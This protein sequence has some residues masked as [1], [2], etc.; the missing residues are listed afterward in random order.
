MPWRGAVEWQRRF[1]PGGSVSLNIGAGWVTF[2]GD[3]GVQNALALLVVTQGN[4]TF[5]ASNGTVVTSAARP[6]SAVNLAANT[7]LSDSSPS[8]GI[9][10]GSTVDAAVAGGASLTAT[11]S[12]VGAA[13]SFGAGSAATPRFRA[14][15]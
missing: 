4:T 9:T 1:V 15:R 10:F 14:S 12:G 2:D 5:A 13:T 7:A 8:K 3:L 11:T 6:D